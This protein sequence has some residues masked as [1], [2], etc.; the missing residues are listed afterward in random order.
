MN[1]GVTVIASNVGGNN[2]ILKNGLLYEY[3]GIRELEQ[4]LIYIENYHQHLECIGYVKNEQFCNKI[5]DGVELLI[6]HLMEN[7]K[8]YDSKIKIWNK[9]MNQIS[10][11]IIKLINMELSS[12]D[13]INKNL[14][15]ITQNFNQTIYINQLLELI[16]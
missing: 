13:M 11:S 4:K 14:E 3:D 5:F 7:N 10:D 9:N 2:E 12:H 8:D 6:P 15:F 16:S 1:Y